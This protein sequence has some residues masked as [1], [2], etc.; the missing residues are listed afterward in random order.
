M[1]E[2][3]RRGIGQALYTAQQGMTDPAAKPLKGFGGARVMEIVERYRRDAYRAVYTAH[4]EN[5]VYMLHVFQ[6][7]SKSG[8]A[9]PKPEIELIRRRFVEAERHYR[10]ERN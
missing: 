7:K 3:V 4:F 1:P 2:Q 6:K 9:T 10:E 8:I 5:A